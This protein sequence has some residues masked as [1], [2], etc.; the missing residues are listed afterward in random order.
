MG[1]RTKRRKLYNEQRY[2]YLCGGPFS[3]RKK[4]RR[5]ELSIDHIVPLCFGGSD[6]KIN[7]AITHRECNLAKSDRLPTDEQ[8]ERLDEQR[9]AH[10]LYWFNAHSE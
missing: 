3:C 1:T 7:Q 6:A 9:R 5:K 8:L 2:C 10:F 4:Q